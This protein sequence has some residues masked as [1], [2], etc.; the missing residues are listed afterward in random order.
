MDESVKVFSNLSEEQML[1]TLN[2]IQTILDR[3]EDK[4]DK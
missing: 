4:E 3:R 2:F 1:M